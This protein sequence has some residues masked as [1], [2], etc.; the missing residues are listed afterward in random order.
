MFDDMSESHISVK[1]AVSS[2]RQWGVKS[3]VTASYIDLKL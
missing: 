1:S 3:E 2:Q